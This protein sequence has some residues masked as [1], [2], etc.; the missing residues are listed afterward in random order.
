MKLS[1]YWY[2][3]W[4]LEEA[5]QEMVNDAPFSTDAEVINAVLAKAQKLNVPLD[6][7]QL[8][9]ER[10]SH[11]GTRLWATYDVRFTF[12]LGFSQTYTFHLEAQSTRR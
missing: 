12:P 4:R 9:I 8:H 2:D 1:V 11:R 5:M 10:S 7:R 3:N 6:P